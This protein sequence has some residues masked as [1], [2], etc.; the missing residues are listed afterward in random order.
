MLGYLKGNE[1]FEHKNNSLKLNKIL[2]AYM[3]K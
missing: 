2:K 1:I 3:L